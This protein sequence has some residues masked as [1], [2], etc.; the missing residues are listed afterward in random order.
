[1]EPAGF[2]FIVTGGVG[3]LGAVR[4]KELDHFSNQCS[5]PYLRACR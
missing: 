5:N 2:H 1:M 4:L 3:G